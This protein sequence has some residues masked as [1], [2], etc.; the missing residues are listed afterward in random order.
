MQIAE[1]WIQ[2][3]EGE[4]KNREVTAMVEPEFNPYAFNWPF[5]TSFD[6]NK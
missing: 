3:D 1:A 6:G 4:L 5:D 2:R